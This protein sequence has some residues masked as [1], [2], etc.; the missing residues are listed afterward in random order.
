MGNLLLVSGSFVTIR[1]Y[2]VEKDLLSAV[3][4]GNPSA[5]TSN[6]VPI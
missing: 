5:E 3:T 1:E 4:V 6:S 2:T